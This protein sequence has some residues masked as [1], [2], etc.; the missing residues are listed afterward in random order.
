M[1]SSTSPICPL[2]TRSIPRRQASHGTLLG[3]ILEDAIVLIDNLASSEIFL[4]A[5]T[6]RLFA[7]DVFA[8]AGGGQ[9]DGHVPVVRGDDMNRIDIV[10][11]QEFA[12]IVE[13]MGHPPLLGPLGPTV[14]KGIAD[15]DDI[16][17]WRS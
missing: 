10:A 15:R 14:R 3:A 2:R 5:D 16:R 7:V 13:L 11:G 9:G 12:E 8:G 17:L 4:D 6:E 1:I